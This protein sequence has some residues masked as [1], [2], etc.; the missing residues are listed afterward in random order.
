MDEFIS[1]TLSM[2]YMQYNQTGNGATWIKETQD[3]QH[4]SV[5]QHSGDDQY[6]WR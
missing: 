2:W 3:Q 4:N 5:Q 6:R 1:D